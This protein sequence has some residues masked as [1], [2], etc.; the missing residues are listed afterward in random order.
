MSIPP[1]GTGTFSVQPVELLWCCV[2]VLAYYLHASCFAC[3][4]DGARQYFLSKRSMDEMTP[5]AKVDR[6]R[7]EFRRADTNRNGCLDQV[8]AV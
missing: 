3:D 7:L 1:T 5:A 4:V 8:S 6:I 2:N